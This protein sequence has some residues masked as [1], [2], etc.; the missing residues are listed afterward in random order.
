MKTI[1]ERLKE[2]EGDVSKLNRMIGERHD[3][4]VIDRCASCKKVEC[5]CEW[6]SDE[7]YDNK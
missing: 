5:E 2:L 3:Y 7:Y 6:D 4:P 1:M